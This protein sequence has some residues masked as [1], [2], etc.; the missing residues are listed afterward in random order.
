MPDAVLANRKELLDYR[1]EF[2]ILAE[3]TY[4]INHSIAAMPRLAEQRLL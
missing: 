3:T 2:P 1:S 4:L